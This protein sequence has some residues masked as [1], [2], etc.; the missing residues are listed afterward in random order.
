M[1]GSTKKYSEDANRYD[2]KTVSQRIEALF[3]NNIGLVVTRDQILR[4]ATNPVTGKEP[5]NWHQRLSELRTD[6]GYT[7]LSWRDSKDLAPQEYDAV[8]YEMRE[9]AACGDN[10]TKWE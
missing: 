1:L 6:K 3:L 5:E 7:I 10:L 4:A 8:M 2:Q 9:H